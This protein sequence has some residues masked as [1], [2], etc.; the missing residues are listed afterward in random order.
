MT[1]GVKI[2]LH[3]S[4]QQ[5]LA[6]YMSIV[7]S[8]A[9]INGM[10]AASCAFYHH[11]ID[12]LSVAEAAELAGMPQ[13]P[14]AYDPRYHSDATWARRTAVLRQMRSE[15]FISADQQLAAEGAPV[16]EGGTGC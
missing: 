2:E 7:P 12:N 9:G 5:I 3:E 10:A 14:S 6:D 16:V 1:V 8:G 15:D 11:G 13:A 4:K